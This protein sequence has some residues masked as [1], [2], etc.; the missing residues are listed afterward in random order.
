M[1]HQLVFSGGRT[2][3][4][5]IVQNSAKESYLHE[6][7]LKGMGDFPISLFYCMCQHFY[8]SAFYPL[9]TPFYTVPL[10]H[11]AIKTY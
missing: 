7:L 9:A 5:N 4:V 3:F 2:P 1:L 11:H 6:V 8:I 10:N